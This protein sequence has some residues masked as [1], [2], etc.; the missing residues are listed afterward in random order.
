M[1]KKCPYCN[2][3]MIIGYIQCRDGICW[4]EK[5]RKIAAL[6]LAGDVVR[7]AAPNNRLFGGVFVEAYNCP[8]CKIIEIGYN[9][10]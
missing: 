3:N 2:T 1:E 5:K 6:A 7:V 9:G 8:K 10:N 4:S